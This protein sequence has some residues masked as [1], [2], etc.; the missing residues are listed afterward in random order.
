VAESGS[1]DR[2]R[3][4]DLD[5]RRV[6]PW[7]RRAVIAVFTAWAI[8]A[9]AGLIGQHPK[10]QSVTAPAASLDLSS[11]SRLRGGLMYQTR[12]IVRASRT[13]QNPRLILDKGFV[14]GITINTIEPEANQE[15]SR[16]DSFVLTYN[17]LS[18][19]DKLTVWLQSQVNPTTVG[20][21]LQ[22][23]SLDD[24][25]TQVARITRH[26]TFFP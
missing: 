17:Q 19:G 8:L 20:R 3:Y 13:L 22:S 18:A 1:L 9:L 6:G 15:L 12:I 23:V 21:R 2:A 16:R 4:R 10:H 25:T 7:V 24:G 14:E 5:R 11:P 26:T